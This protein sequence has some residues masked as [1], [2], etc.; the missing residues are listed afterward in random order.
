MKVHRHQ[1]TTYTFYNLNEPIPSLWDKSKPLAVIERVDLSYTV[2][3]EPEE[4]CEPEYMDYKLT[5]YDCKADGTRDGR[6]KRPHWVSFPQPV[7]LYEFLTRL[8][9]EID[10]DGI[11]KMV[12]EGL[13][14]GRK[15]RDEQRERLLRDA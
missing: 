13:E 1:T 4:D 10:H 15:Q 8:V 14:R 12:A 9:Q 11:K 6:Q 7:D 3:D 5:G 2:Y